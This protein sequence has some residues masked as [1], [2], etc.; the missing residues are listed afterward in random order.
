MRYTGFG[1]GV[2]EAACFIF[3]TVVR[4][5]VG[6]NDDLHLFG[7]M[8]KHILLKEEIADGSNG[9]KV[10]LRAEVAENIRCR[11]RILIGVTEFEDRNPRH[12]YRRSHRNLD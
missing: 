5:Q 12:R 4:P 7:E 6:V 8:F 1:L 11:K 3:I 9:V 10:E 2:E